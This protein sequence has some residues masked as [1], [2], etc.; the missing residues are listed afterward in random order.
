MTTKSN[1]IVIGSTGRNTGKT[2]FACRLIE[3]YSKEH[4]VVGIKVVAINR[5]AGNCPRG[6]KGCGVCQSLE[7]DYE[8]F[9]EKIINPQKDTSRML[10]AGAQKVFFLK[11]DE[12]C[13]PQG[14]NAIL[15]VIPENAMVVIES[16]SIRKVLEPGL[17]IVIKN[18]VDKTVKDS[19]AEVI[20]FANKVIE[21]NN[22]SW[23]FSPE[24]VIIK[25]NTWIIREKATAIIL[26][27]GKSSRMGG[28][29]KSLLPIN[30][31][32]LIQH[33]V[34]QLE[35]HFE[36]ILIGANDAEKYSFLNLEVIPD[37][38]KDM[39]PLMGIYSCL[40]A[41]QND[42]NFITACDIPEMNIKLINNM[43]NLSTNN[44]I[45]MPVKGENMHEPLF[46]VYNK[47]VANIAEGIIASNGR[48]IIEFIGK[49][50]VKYVEF[51][52]QSWY[53]N[54]NLKDDYINY[55]KQ[56]GERVCNKDNR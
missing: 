21:F 7:G 39:G 50:K 33:I 35:G 28:N 53:Q 38:E 32:P 42:I 22:M 23:N 48:R 6:G 44:D 55:I 52:D 11:V 19:C 24:R 12:N 41:S 54:L 13:L 2:E 20:G 5:S 49:C 8:I 16:N 40:K 25:D 4:F 29:D 46:A 17:F 37:I 43:I 51:N 34:K 3:K 18:L 36:Q 45:V 9:E 1:F 31:V 47:G 10:M 14:L 26:A 15:E 30:G 27:G 56:T